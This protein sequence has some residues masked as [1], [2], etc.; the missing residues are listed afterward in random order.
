MCR[1][2]CIS[3]PVVTGLFKKKK[4]VTGSSWKL[5]SCMPCYVGEIS[6]YTLT[7]F[8]VFR[9]NYNVVS[10]YNGAFYAFCNSKLV[11]QATGVIR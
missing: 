4:Y 1:H 10:L 5:V 11:R 3:F 6:C 2:I 9:L 8:Q 7:R